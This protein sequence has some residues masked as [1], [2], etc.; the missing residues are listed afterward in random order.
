MIE[1][2]LLPEKLRLAHKEKKPIKFDLPQTS[3]KSLSLAI[4]SV[5]ILIHIILGLF[6]FAKKNQMVRLKERLKEI[7]PKE[8]TF[9]ELK[10]QS[11]E[12]SKKFQAIDSLTSGSLLWSKKMHDLSEAMIDGVWLTSIYLNTETSKKK[13]PARIN[14]DTQKKPGSAARVTPA[15]ETIIRQA[16][17]FRGSAVSSIPGEETAI[18]GKFIESLRKHKAFFDDFDEIKLSSS[19]TKELGDV[20]VM[21]F[22][23]VCYFKQGRSYFEKLEEIDTDK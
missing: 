13:A 11:D 14:T 17:V 10:S 7:A 18:V 15:E 23:L 21:D 9:K 19:L 16:L 4:I 8:S 5:V 12:L 6:S 20:E 22:A 2:N 1:L 3:L